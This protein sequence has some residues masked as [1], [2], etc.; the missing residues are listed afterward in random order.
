MRRRTYVRR[1]FFCFEYFK[2]YF[3]GT[4]NIVIRLM[5]QYNVLFFI[6]CNLNHVLARIFIKIV[7]FTQY[8]LCKTENRRKN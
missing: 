1:L 6:L 3:F 2:L 8:V 7:N 5:S 4:F